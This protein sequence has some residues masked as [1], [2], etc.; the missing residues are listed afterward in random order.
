M[1]GGRTRRRSWTLRRRIVQGLILTFY[2]AL[3]I[4]AVRNVTAVAGSLAALRLGPFDLVEP[5]GALSAVLASRS[6]TWALALGVLPVVLLALFAGPVFCSWVCPWGLASEF[7]DRFRHRKPKGWARA[8]WTRARIPRASGLALVM[9][10]SLG[11]AIPLAAI[12]SAPR[13]VTALPLEVIFLGVVS[14]VTVG[15]LL[16]LAI[17]EVLGPR[18]LWCRAVCPV[19]ALA[20]FLRTPRTLRVSFAADRCLEPEAAACHRA[21][22]W[23]VDPRQAGRFDGCTNCFACVDR[24]PS[25]AL[26]PG[27][28]TPAGR[29]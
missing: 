7:I 14:P 21:C 23:G 9:A 5:A 4:A 26:T 28:R 22:A 8:S 15:L 17:F 12:L 2:L 6:A 10:G 11:L 18:R 3:P 24:C 16:A 19:G 20:N 1:E 25:G 29:P 13:L 27:A